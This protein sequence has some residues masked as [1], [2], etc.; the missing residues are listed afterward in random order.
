M[1]DD[2][3]ANWKTRPGAVTTPCCTSRFPELTPYRR[4][5]TV[6]DLR[7]SLPATC[8]STTRLNLVVDLWRSLPTTC[9]STTRPNLVPDVT[10]LFLINE[11]VCYQPARIYDVHCPAPLADC[12]FSIWI[13]YNKIDSA[14]VTG[15]MNRITVHL[16]NHNWAYQLLSRMILMMNSADHADD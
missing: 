16:E 2:P 11:L 12:L 14:S 1:V 5:W 9:D 6:V 10:V 15:I 7:R 3:F 13:C 4:S 8:D